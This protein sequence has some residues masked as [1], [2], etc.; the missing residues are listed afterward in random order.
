MFLNER[1]DLLVFVGFMF[2]PQMENK[3][4]N[5]SNSGYFPTWFS[6]TDLFFPAWSLHDTVYPSDLDKT[7]W[8]WF[9]VS[10]IDE[11]EDVL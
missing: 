9:P 2:L 4:K 7:E 8:N 10:L 1:K 5:W 6:P 11:I 3:S